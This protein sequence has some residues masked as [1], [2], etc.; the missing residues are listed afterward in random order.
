MVGHTFGPRFGE[1]GGGPREVPFEAAAY[2]RSMAQGG[3]MRASNELLRTEHLARV[4]RRSRSVNVV[5]IGGGTGLPR[6]LAGLA[7]SSEL[8]AEP[9][10]LE[11]TAVVAT[12]DDGGSSG[13]LRRSYGIPA[14]GDV[15][16]CLVALSST[17]DP[18][19][20]VFQHRFDGAG[21]LSGHTVGNVFLAALIQHLGGFRV[22]VEV[23]GD[24]LGA[25]GRVLPAT[26]EQ[27]DL[28]ATLDDGRVVRGEQAIVHSGGRVER[29]SL[30]RPV[31]AL[32][33]VVD[34]IAAAD[35]VVL[36]PGSLYSSVIAPLLGRGVTDALRR[37][38]GTRV[39]VVNLFTEVG[40]TDGYSAADHVRA[41]Q[42]H[43]GPVLDVALVHDRPLRAP[44]QAR[45]CAVRV[46]PVA[47]A[48]LGVLPFA[49]NV[50][51]TE[52]TP[53][54]DPD[55]LACVLLGFARTA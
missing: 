30:D 45:P 19:A 49:A 11:V 47:I 6:V 4:Q 46:D 2:G 43:A 42:R 35:L 52:G 55:R 50:V 34:A 36:G 31:D 38:R 8:R 3:E 21:G 9:G 20:A 54:H 26:E 12:S 22:A 17:V 39:L 18:L 24:L 15:R 14:T 41:I 27:V 32:P 40:E 1:A 25:R 16:N 48:E 10:G 37:C 29:V 5:A 33:A 13:E 53:R 51:A 7:R 23:A 28:V 44:A